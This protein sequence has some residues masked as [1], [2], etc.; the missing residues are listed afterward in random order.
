MHRVYL[1]LLITTALGLFA[2]AD[3]VS[4]AEEPAKKDVP[5]PGLKYKMPEIMLISWTEWPKDPEHQDTLAKYIKEKGFNA[6]ETTMESLD[7]LRK[8]GMYARL[9]PELGAAAKLKDDPA[10]FCYF[11][12][13]RRR[14]SSFPG[15]AHMR[16]EFEKADPNHPTMFINRAL[17]NQFPGFVDVVK[18]NLLTYYHYQWRHKQ[19][20]ERNLL[21]LS[22][23]RDLAVKN[24]IPLL[25]CTDA[26]STPGQIRQE[27]FTSLAYGVKGF[28]YSPC[29]HFGYKKDEKGEPVLEN[30]KIV[31]TFNEFFIP[32][33]DI[34][35]DI[36]TLSPVLV[37][38]KSVDVF[39]AEPLPMAGKK[40]PED[41]WIG[42]S[43]EGT[44]VGV[45]QDE[46]GADFLLPVNNDPNAQREATLRLKGATAVER[47]DKKSG[48]WVPL[49]LEKDG[50]A[51]VVKVP[52]APGDGEL[53]KVIKS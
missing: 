1:Y 14:P 17:W 27:H 28:H 48:I 11:I 47:M 12:S 39:H 37:K 4:L 29:H 50:D 6:V 38:L 18:P 8:N 7:T 44:L 33:S 41:S 36:K 21:Y 15:F 51:G 16:Q 46:A 20:P 32:L 42:I 3:R 30:G 43:G 19:Y 22:M 34:A 31:P 5:Y 53:L 40:P 13:D 45:L 23:F 35:K 9:G 26:R 25:R 2:F 24:D 49:A 52:L 10:V